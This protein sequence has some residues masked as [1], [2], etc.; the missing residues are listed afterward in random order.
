MDLGFQLK[1]EQSLKLTM[2]PVMQ[3]SIQLLQLSCMDLERY[4]TEWANENPLIELKYSFR[5]LNYQQ[6]ENITSNE[7]TLE[8][9]LI[10]QLN[11]L[12]LSPRIYHTACYLAGSLN[13]N[14]YLAGQLDEISYAFNLPREE[15]EIGLRILQSLEPS[16][17]GARSVKE[18]LLLQIQRD[19]Y[20]EPLAYEAVNLYLDKL[21]SR[22]LKEIASQ[23]H[24]SEEEVQYVLD[25][26]QTLN[27]KPGMGY[28]HEVKHSIIPEARVSIQ[29]EQYQVQMYDAYLPRVIVD[30][31][32]SSDFKEKD[33][34]EAW[35]YYKKQKESAQA[36]I[37]GLDL[38]KRTLYQVIET[39]VQ[40]QIRFFEMGEAGLMPL[41]LK[42]V[43]DPLGLHESTIS[44]AIRNKYIETSKGLY[45]LK[46][47]FSAALRTD[48]GEELSAKSVKWRI[49]RMVEQ[50]S[51]A[52]PLSDQRIADLLKAEGIQI[53]RR[54]VTKYREELKIQSSVQRKR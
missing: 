42:E 23:L 39:I 31:S 15:V 38:R 2:T 1:Q 9:F 43:G 24:I 4:L 18:C 5:P 11:F 6:I 3:Q 27:P 13:E 33:A 12:N 40:K 35:A 50:E 16:G 47:F 22:K 32:Y 54:T 20:A 49:K 19:R 29:G 34:P 41:T 14:G 36:M 37:H 26:I 53:S 25:Y 45:E 8:R 28:G 48:R 30:E 17:I 52:Q 7:E 44:R 46:S 51:T 10:H 21:A